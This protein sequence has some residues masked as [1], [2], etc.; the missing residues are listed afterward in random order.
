[1]RERRGSP[2][3]RCRVPCVLR[4]GAKEAQGVLLDVSLSGLSVQTSVEL[5]QGDEVE[6][7][8]GKLRVPAIAWHARRTRSGFVVGMMLSGV[9]LDYERF[10]EGLAPPR[11][12]AAGPRPP[13]TEIRQPESWWKLRVK[14]VDGPRTRVVTLAAETRERAVEQALREIG[15]GWEVL[16]AR[17]TT[18]G[19]RKAS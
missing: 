16:E 19:E 5:G 6:V 7:A 15:G 2:R 4:Q 12:R 8:A 17:P 3:H 9:S 10:V 11:A 13:L 1:M 18:P 14:E